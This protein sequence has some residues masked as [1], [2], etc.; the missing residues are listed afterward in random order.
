VDSGL[1]Y[2]RPLITQVQSLSN[3]LHSLLERFGIAIVW[4]ECHV[5]AFVFPVLDCRGVEFGV[6]GRDEQAVRFAR[7]GGPAEVELHWGR[8]AGGRSGAASFL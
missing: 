8:G 2:E 6:L 1:T 5:E 7:P 4:E 3:V